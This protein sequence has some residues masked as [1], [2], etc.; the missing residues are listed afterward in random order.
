MSFRLFPCLQWQV[1]SF[2]AFCDISGLWTQL[3]WSWAFG[4]F[5]G[6]QIL[7]CSVC[8]FRIS[9][10]VVVSK[11]FCRLSCKWRLGCSL[12]CASLKRFREY[13]IK[14]QTLT[15]NQPPKVDNLI[16]LKS[17]NVTNWIRLYWVFCWA[18]ATVLAL[19]SHRG[20]KT[21]TVKIE[22]FAYTR[23]RTFIK[24]KFCSQCS[25]SGRPFKLPAL[26]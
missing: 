21:H 18:L 13:I 17:A 3:C 14:T 8:R 20:T 5:V 11:A 2:A 23:S 19:D 7:D 12:W 1:P 26:W 24:P 22:R 4:S 25:I 15:T 16:T 10:L 9:G 6:F